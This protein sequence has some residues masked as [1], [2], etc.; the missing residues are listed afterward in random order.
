MKQLSKR[1]SIALIA[2]LLLLSSFS[3][4]ASASWVPQQEIN[5]GYLSSSRA[6]G[7]FYLHVSGFAHFKMS[8][9]STYGNVVPILYQLQP[10]NTWTAVRGRTLDLY[11]HFAP[12]TGTHY[13]VNINESSYQQPLSPGVYKL[14]INAPNDVYL[15]DW[16]AHVVGY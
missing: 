12:Y 4:S 3:G 10:N 1:F 9:T 11:N 16:Q 8:S 13:N 7:K 15:A 14:V 6:D 2:A 5:L